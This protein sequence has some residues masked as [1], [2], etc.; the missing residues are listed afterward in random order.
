MIAAKLLVPE[1]EDEDGVESAS[2]LWQAVQIVVVAD[3]VMSLDNVIAVAA[4]ANGSV[5]LAG[6]RPCHQRAPDRRRCGA[7]HGAADA[8]AD[9]GVGWRGAARLDR[10]RGDRDRSRRSSRSCTRCSRS[11]RRHAGLD[12]RRPR[13]SRRNSP[14]AAA[15]S[16]IVL[17]LLGVVVVLVVG[18][19][20]AGA[21][22]RRS[23]R[24]RRTRRSAS[25]NRLRLRANETRH[26]V[27]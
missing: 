19:S 26:D 11:V 7:D 1:Q 4:A 22:W 13:A 16:E 21:H 17:R 2:H 18:S 12:A 27:I 3:I 15:A 5:P 24:I 25:A 6:A 14:M 8:A 20:G 23:R 10:G 9:P